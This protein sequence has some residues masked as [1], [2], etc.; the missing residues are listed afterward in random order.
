MP[1][2]A[3]SSKKTDNNIVHEGYNAFGDDEFT[4]MT[5]TTPACG[6]NDNE[7]NATPQQPPA[8]SSSYQM[9]VAVYDELRGPEQYPG[10]RYCVDCGAPSPDWGSPKLGILM[11]FQCSGVHRGLGVHLSFVRSVQMDHWTDAQLACMRM[12][13]NDACNTFLASHGIAVV[14]AVDNDDNTKRR[15][16]IR[17]KYDSDAALL[18]Q[19]VLLAKVE[20]RPIPTQLQAQQRRDAAPR[21]MRK[22]E[23]FGSAPPPPV[24]AAPSNMPSGT[25]AAVVCCGVAVVATAVWI[26]APH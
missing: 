20:G 6:A 3:S 26:M 7:N 12:G 15:Q 10:N 22:M 24:S 16:L 18:Y 11:C 4:T 21:P 13:G 8:S 9:P 14:T 2:S 25:V 5:T 17:T 23:G 19:Q 1:F